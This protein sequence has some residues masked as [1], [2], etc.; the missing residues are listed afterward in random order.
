MKFLI[1]LLLGILISFSSFKLKLLSRS[2][3]VATFLLAFIIFF[4]GEIKWTFPILVF[5]ILSSVLTK[6]RKRFN[7]VIDVSL[8]RADL[9]DHI[10]VFANGGLAGILTLLNHL[11]V[12]ELFYVS[13]VS[14]IAAVCA[15]TWSTEIGTL[16]RV[17]T[18]NIMSFKFV[19]QGIS[20]G[21]SFIGFVGAMIGSITIASSSLFWLENIKLF[22]PVII[23]SG[24]LGSV[25]DSVLGSTIQLKLKCCV[26][27]KI[28]ERKTHCGLDA[29]HFKGIR[30]LNNDWVNFFTSVFGASTSLL[31]IS[32]YL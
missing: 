4:F 15:D 20:G 29:K 17:K 31:L 2:G 21:V 26:C 14:A 11:L 12:S 5:F 25:F 30:W 27:N 22:L 3:A 8:Q 6:I 7:P 24:F 23:L 19:E 13:Y 10:Q 16:F 18:Y 9:R 1:S 28:T 32:Y